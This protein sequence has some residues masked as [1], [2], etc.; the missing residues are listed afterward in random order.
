MNW[1]AIGAIGEII[2]ATGV[3][4]SLFYVAYQVRL[5]TKQT[6]QNTAA[7]EAASEEA[8]ANLSTV[9]RWKV[10]ESEEVATIYTEGLKDPHSLS[11]IEQVRFRAVLAALLQLFQLIHSQD[12]NNRVKDFDWDSAKPTIR[13][14]FGTNGGRWYWKNYQEEWS[15]EFRES[16]SKLVSEDE[17]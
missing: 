11:E 7:L 12:R 1:E 15:S 6:D 9:A 2:G 4:L 16:I 3:I 5:N 8:M 17:T 13:R 14:M 10:A